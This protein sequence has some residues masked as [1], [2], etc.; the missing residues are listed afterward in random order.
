MIYI[1]T[2]PYS[3][4]MYSNCLIFNV[5]KSSL[6]SLIVEMNYKIVQVEILVFQND[7]LKN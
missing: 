4:Q 6:S 5:V 1:H 2:S 3:L 7:F